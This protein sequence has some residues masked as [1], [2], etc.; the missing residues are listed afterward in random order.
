MGPRDRDSALRADQGAQGLGILDAGDSAAVRLSQ[1][2][3]IGREGGGADEEVELSGQR[4]LPLPTRDREPLLAELKD[5]RRGAPIGAAH[6]VP[7]ALK[8]PSQPRESRAPDPAQE[9]PQGIAA[10]RPGHALEQDLLQVGLRSPA[11]PRA[12]STLALS[13]SSYRSGRALELRT[14]F[15][16]FDFAAP[17]GSGGDSGLRSGEIVLAIPERA[18]QT[19]RSA[20]DPD[21]PSQANPREASCAALSESS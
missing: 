16:G 11:S 19:L 2:G 7:Q 5:R 13:L 10:R 3:V 21:R 20:C 15:R 12:H 6:A 14:G 1:L 17:A 9:D 8:Q 18:C 4:V